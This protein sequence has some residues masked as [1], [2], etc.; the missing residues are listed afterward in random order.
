MGVPVYSSMGSS[1]KP[2]CRH[3]YVCRIGAGAGIGFL[4][5]TPRYCPQAKGHDGTRLEAPAWRSEGCPENRDCMSRCAAITARTSFSSRRIEAVRKYPR[6]GGTALRCSRARVLLDDESCSHPHAGGD[7]P[8]GALI[9][10]IASQ[11][12]RQLQKRFATTGHLFERRY[13]ALIV[14]ANAYLLMAHQAVALRIDSFAH[15]APCSAAMSR[16]YARVSNAIS[17]LDNPISAPA[18]EAPHRAPPCAARHRTQIC[19]MILLTDSNLLTQIGY[20]TR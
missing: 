9:Q 10:R 14:G 5:C 16:R 18:P 12:A 8:L 11:Y 13:H 19:T 15:V 1:K 3:M 6:T 7:T 4:D 17:L 20:E 2:G